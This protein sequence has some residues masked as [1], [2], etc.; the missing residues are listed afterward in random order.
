M[1]T[2]ESFEK[3]QAAA[4]LD[5]NTEMEDDENKKHFMSQLVFDINV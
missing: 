3:L 5:W 4:E 2:G 1:G